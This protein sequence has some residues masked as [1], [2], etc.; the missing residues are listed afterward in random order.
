M[1][2]VHR[3]AT[4]F[5][6]ALT[7][8]ALAPSRPAQASPPDRL[9]LTYRVYL[10]GLPIVE[11]ETRAVVDGGRYR[12]DNM[13]RTT[14]LW[15][16][17]FKARM[18]S[19][20]DGRLGDS[21][22][23]APRP[24]LFQ[25]RYDGR[26]GKRRSVDV[27]FDEKGPSEIVAVPPN[28]KDGRSL[29]EPEFLLGATDPGTA[30]LLAAESGDGGQICQRSFKI[31]DGRRRYDIAFENKG[32]DTLSGG[33]GEFY[34]GDAT[35]CLIRYK[36]IKGFDPAWEKAESKNYPN[37]VD[38]WFVRF[39]EMPRAIPVRVQVSTEYG[40]VVAQLVRRDLSKGEPLNDA[41]TLLPP[42]D[43]DK[44]GG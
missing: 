21:V 33:H 14:G 8:P 17:L 16:S 27:Y 6:L 15:E 2:L 13:T 28:E 5:A 41:A 30:A 36:R 12:L 23:E 40:V 35:H 31:F 3:L 11:V 43:L 38:I 34:T 39:P 9:D 42:P 29:I 37:E 7:L 10:G 22:D 1:R 4:V 20:V 44:M 32:P 26:V 25:V 19:R 24:S 18:Q